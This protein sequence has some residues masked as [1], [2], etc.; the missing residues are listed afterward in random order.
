MS[1]FS[2][3]FGTSDTSATGQEN[4]SE[5]LSSEEHEQQYNF[6][7]LRDDGLRSLNAGQPTLA[8]KYLEEALKYRDDDETW[9]HLADAY[10]RCGQGETALPI[11]D[12]LID[13]HKDQPKLYVAAAQAAEQARD[14][15]KME[16]YAHQ[17]LRLEETNDVVRFLLARAQYHLH[18]YISAIATLTQLLGND[19]GYVPVRQLRA[20]TLYEMNQYHEAEKDI[21]YMLDHETGTED[22]YLLKAKLCLSQG[23][24]QEALEACLQILAINPF[25]REAPL[26]AAQ[27]YMQ[28]NRLDK[29]LELLNET[30]EMMPDLAEGYKLRGRVKHLLHDEAGAI[31]D[32]KRSVELAP[33]QQQNLTGTFCNIQDG[34]EIK[35]PEINPFG[36]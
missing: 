31:E 23:R 8:V 20:Q 34:A 16:D 22:C 33:E 2:K 17:A 32:L 4:S 21:Q 14:W 15:D 11:L 27:I 5:S 1:I 13:K 30:L 12:K 10:I 6:E 36:L 19:E 25:H 18:D 24:Q 28:T 7:T 3:I 9:G 29:A 35:L 26:M